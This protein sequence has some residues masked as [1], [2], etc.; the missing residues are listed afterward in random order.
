MKYILI[1]LII[2]FFQSCEIKKLY[3]E[4]EL[5]PVPYSRYYCDLGFLQN[6]NEETVFHTDGKSIKCNPNLIRMTF[7]EFTKET[8]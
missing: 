4:T 6:N 2:L 8:K 3:I 7:G 1:C 5:G